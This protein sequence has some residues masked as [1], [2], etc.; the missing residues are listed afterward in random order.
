[1]IHL[2]T[3]NPVLAG[4]LYYSGDGEAT[5]TV[6][7]RSSLPPIPLDPRAADGA[8]VVVMTRGRLLLRC[9]TEPRCETSD[10]WGGMVPR[11]SLLAR[12]FPRAHQSSDSLPDTE[13]P[14]AG[15]WVIDIRR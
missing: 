14:S 12:T 8:D 5:A 13:H 9:L 7:P 15:W 6:M 4:G 10:S 11:V 1:V 3:M 2:I